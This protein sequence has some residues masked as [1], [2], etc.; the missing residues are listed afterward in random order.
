MMLPRRGYVTA[1]LARL[2]VEN[3]LGESI[4]TS[5]SIHNAKINIYFFCTEPSML[6]QQNT[7]TAVASLLETTSAHLSDDMACNQDDQC[8]HVPS[9]VHPAKQSNSHAS[10]MLLT[11]QTTPGRHPCD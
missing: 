10:T 3:S 1:L 6:L 4:I 5:I 8:L 11:L 2:A 9:I 7:L